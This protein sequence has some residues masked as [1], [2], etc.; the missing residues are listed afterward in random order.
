[1]PDMHGVAKQGPLPGHRGVRPALTPA[2]QA[3]WYLDR[4]H[5]GTAMYNVPFAARLTGPLDAA[6][7]RAALGRV[8]TRHD[9]LRTTFRLHRGEPYQH[10]AAAG[11]PPPL[12]PVA[13]LTDLPPHARERRADALRE[14]WS[15]Q[16]FDLAH[17][18]LLRSMLVRLGRH[19]HVLALCLHHAV[20]DAASID[21]LFDELGDAYGGG[22]P[23][24]PPPLQFADWADWLRRQPDDPSTV[25]WWRDYLRDVPVT[26]GFPEAGASD[27]GGAE[28][29]PLARA[30]PSETLHAVRDYARSARTTPFVVMLA[31]YAAL[32]G[33]LTGR[34][35]LVVGVPASHRP[36]P[37]LEALIGLFVDTVA[38]K[39]D[40][41]GDPVFGELVSRVRASLLAALDHRAPFDAVVGALRL[42]REGDTPPLVQATF[43][44]ENTPPV[45][46]RFAGLTARLLPSVTLPGK[47][48]L[49]MM[50][51]PAQDGADGHQ[52]EFSH[53]PGLFHPRTAA[54]L[55]EILIGVLA[56]AR[57][58]GTRLS[59]LLPADLGG[60]PPV[61]VQAA[62]AQPTDVPVH[63]LIAYQAAVTPDAPA[64]RHGDDTVTYAELEA[65]A[66]A[67]A[68]RL[69]RAGVRA[70][71]VVGI[72]LPRCAGIVTAVLA[73]LKTGAAYLPLALT[74]SPEHRARQ[75][76]HGGVQVILTDRANAPQLGD[77]GTAAVF[78]DGP[79]PPEGADRQE[80]TSP[81]ARVR[82]G[83]LAYVLYTSGSTGQ[84]KAVG[85]PHQALVNHALNVR[86]LF[87][88]TPR[89]RVLQFAQLTFDVA[90]EEIFPTL[91]AGA[92]VVVSADP[93]APTEA[94]SLLERERITVA[95]LP[96]GYW[97][98]WAS[99][100]STSAPFPLPALRLMA[101]GSERVDAASLASWIRWSRVPVLN[102]Y[103]LTETTVTALVHRVPADFRD[104]TVPV[105]TPLDGVAAYVLDSALRPVRPGGEGELYLAGAGLARGYLRLP[106][107]TADRF[108][109][110]PYSPVPGGRMHRTGDR[111]RL[112]GD[113][114]IEVLGRLDDQLKVNGYRV[115]PLHVEAALT[116]H[117]AIAQ[118]AVAVRTTADGVPRLVGYVIRVDGS[119][120]IPD[121][122]RT[123]LAALLPFHL[124]PAA[125]TAL[126][127]LPVAPSG[128]IDRAALPE[129]ESPHRATATAPVSPWEHTIR[130]IWQN[131]LAVDR[132]GMHD[133][134]FD[135]GG[136][137]FALATVHTRISRLLETPV[138]LTALYENPTV[139]ALAHE[140]SARHQNSPAPS[141]ATG[142]PTT[143][144]ARTGLGRLARK[145]RRAKP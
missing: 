89:D 127:A 118:A 42:P 93:P 135:V 40:L 142:T 91:L 102:A 12:L 14:E 45:P 57:R 30:I 144:G 85:V 8:V 17:G 56:G 60:A 2:Q 43:G 100:L 69:H 77:P 54:R 15:R 63:Q 124:I 130:T 36:L 82:P 136:T 90:A 83:D 19:D 105:G 73:V 75:A 11:A 99:S 106:G 88:L 37:E 9:A 5:P 87:E 129:P 65:A 107:L 94:T 123:H 22:P 112:R 103:G 111:A 10:I 86:R 29:P 34:T 121:D 46:P 33:H 13:D 84:P 16:P 61:P 110:D 31:A 21:L 139:A 81:P 7:L 49:D 71:D 38:V 47:F 70:G 72:L 35:Q 141:P 51:A 59:A 115:E 143:P 92:C 1:M 62:P 126:S 132:V 6:A 140:L 113:G 78:L 66:D 96:S 133:N 108:V 97:Q 128:K 74:S 68:R 67:A 138:P 114:S 117:P 58:P 109:P 27:G 145:R 28:S 76:R 116:A 52:V 131:V 20:C 95:N 64:V 134:F 24:D 23:E 120:R 98:R 4:L 25:A 119:T 79:E 137:S 32:L 39:A 53:A 48:D 80:G 104:P 41:S 125:F 44:F 3:L 26:L 50:V 55:P 101:I 122:L 18:P